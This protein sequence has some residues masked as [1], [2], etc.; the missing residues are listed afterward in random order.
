MIRRPPRSTQSRS[1]AASDVYKRQVP[2]SHIQTLVPFSWNGPLQVRPTVASWSRMSLAHSP[3]S[4]RVSSVGAA[5]LSPAGPPAGS[6][7]AEP[8]HA[9]AAMSMPITKLVSHERHIG[10]RLLREVFDVAENR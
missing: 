7:G 8:L 2:D 3:R 5:A 1:S 4:Q 6:F 9:A 10:S